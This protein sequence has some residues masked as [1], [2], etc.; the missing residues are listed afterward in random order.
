MHEYEIVYGRTLRGARRSRRPARRRHLRFRC[1]N[2]S[3]RRLGAHVQRGTFG[4]FKKRAVELYDAH[5]KFAFK[6]KLLFEPCEYIIKCVQRFLAAEAFLSITVFSLMRPVAISLTSIVQLVHSSSSAKLN[7][8]GFEPS[9]TQWTR[10][11]TRAPFTVT[12]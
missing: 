10:F 7:V 9:L 2:L 4:N 1:A 6:S 3:G 8:Y 11:S 12:R 5:S